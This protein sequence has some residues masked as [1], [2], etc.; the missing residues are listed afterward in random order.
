VEEMTILVGDAGKIDFG[1]PLQLTPQ[2]R[3]GFLAFLQSMFIVV[4]TRQVTRFREERLGDRFFN[5]AWTVQELAQLFDWRVDQAETARR[6]GRGGMSVQMQAGNFTPGFL[7]WCRTNDKDPARDELTELIRLYLAH[8]N[9]EKFAQRQARLDRKP[10]RIRK[11][12]EAA[13]VLLGSQ[14]LVNRARGGKD[15]D[16]LARISETKVAIEELEDQLRAAESS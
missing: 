7:S 12:I 16:M 4:E 9:I 10:S 11:R 6:L 2:Q 8:Q 3:E 15:A 13:Q 5:R 1:S 14:E